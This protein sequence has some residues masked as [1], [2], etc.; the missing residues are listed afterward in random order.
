M[1]DLSLISST[2]GDRNYISGEKVFQFLNRGK[3]YEI[4]YDAKKFGMR[5]E[6]REL[7]IN[8]CLPKNIRPFKGGQNRF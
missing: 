5:K 7:L 3:G 2:E 1:R 4:S 8:L 6:N